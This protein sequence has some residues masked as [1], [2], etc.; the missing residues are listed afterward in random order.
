MKPVTQRRSTAILKAA[1]TLQE[2]AAFR[3]CEYNAHVSYFK[4]VL[5]GLVRAP[6]NYYWRFQ[7]VKR[8][9][10]AAVGNNVFI[11]LL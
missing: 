5:A 7:E 9:P 6:E 4:S 10:R 2:C 8:S 3:S 11:S 1:Y